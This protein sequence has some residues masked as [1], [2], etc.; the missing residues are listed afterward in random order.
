MTSLPASFCGVCGLEPDRHPGVPCIT[1]SGRHWS[2]LN[3][4]DSQLPALL[5]IALTRPELRTT[6]EQHLLERWS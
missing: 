2:G 1:A 3:G 4:E 6:A 5:R